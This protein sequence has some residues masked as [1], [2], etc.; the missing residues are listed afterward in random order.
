MENVITART[1][2]N[3]AD[4]AHE[5]ML[6]TIHDHFFPGD[7]WEI[8]NDD[9][10]GENLPLYITDDYSPLTRLLATHRLA[11]KSVYDPEL[12]P[13]LEKMILDQ[14]N[15]SNVNLDFDTGALWVIAKLFDCLGDEAQATTLRAWAIFNPYE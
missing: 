4:E 5:S 11:G 6:Q 10:K 8:I 7:I 9:T 2:K 14:D 13:A 12:L 3:M 15:G 1:L